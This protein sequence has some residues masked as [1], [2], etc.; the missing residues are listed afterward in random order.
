M[1]D[2]ISSVVSLLNNCVNI[3]PRYGNG[4]ELMAFKGTLMIMAMIDSQMK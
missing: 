3:V 2:H 1:K 4:I